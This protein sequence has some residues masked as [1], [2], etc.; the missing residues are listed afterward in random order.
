MK[1]IVQF[2]LKPGSKNK[3]LEAFESRGPNRNPGVTIER[4]WVGTKSDLV[5]AL[6]EGDDESLVAKA[7]QAWRELGEF[8]IHPVIDVEQ[9]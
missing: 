9:Y 7:G 3:A 8:Q 6:V 5:F 1:F 4:A 2:Q